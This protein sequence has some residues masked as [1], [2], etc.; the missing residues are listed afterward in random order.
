MLFLVTAFPQDRIHRGVLPDKL[1]F[2]ILS[3]MCQLNVNGLQGL[4]KIETLVKE[5]KL[6]GNYKV[7]WNITNLPSGVYFYRLHAGPFIQT[8]KMILIK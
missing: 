8:R 7:N 6:V 5:E 1:N 2:N 3:M 4:T